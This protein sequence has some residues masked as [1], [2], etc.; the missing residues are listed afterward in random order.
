MIMRHCSLALLCLLAGSLIKVQATDLTFQSG[1]R[2]PVVVELYTSEGC[3]SCPPAEAYL[4]RLRHSPELWKSIFPVAFHVDYWDGLGWPDRF[5]RAEYTQRQRVYAAQLHQDSVYT[6]EFVVNGREWRGF[7]NGGT[8]PS[9]PIAAGNQLSLK[10][11]DDGRAVSASFQGAAGSGSPTVNVAVLGMG[12]VSN[13]QRGEN[14]G[15]KLSHDFVVLDFAGKSMTRNG[16]AWVSGAISLRSHT[17]DEPAAVVAWVSDDNGAI[18][19]A[20]GGSLKS[21]AVAAAP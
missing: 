11:G 21:P 9:T 13:V 2:A 7:F 4:G 19:Q 6:P 8:L 3:S 5:A 16:P 18:L 12:I 15:Q 17:T 14:A 20:A 10:V 1:N